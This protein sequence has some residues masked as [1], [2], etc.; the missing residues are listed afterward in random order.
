MKELIKAIRSAANMNQEQFAS[1]LG[2]TPLSI[3]RWE[4]GK[5]LPNRMA[6]TQLYNFCKERELD[7]VEIIVN[8][9]EY[10]D[11]N[12]KLVLYH[13]SKKGIDGDIAPISR[14]E[15]DFGKGFY[16]GTT[17]LQPL[18]LVCNEDKPKF[19][20]VEL[21]TTDLKVLTVDIG[22]D[23]AMLIAYYR[24]EM[25]SAKGT[26][27][28]EK[29]AHMADGYDLI[30]GYIA[31]DRMYT[32]L[33]RFFNRTLTDVALINCL[34]ALDLGKQYVAVSE[35]AC[36][37]IKVLKEYPLSQLELA[38][39]KDMSAERR[40]EGIALAEEI[41]VKYRREGKFFDEIL[42]GE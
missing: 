19:Y 31:N 9:K 8:A 23:W 30:I 4:N 37:Q 11:E 15:C 28:Y 40:K 1:A 24:K 18:T 2:T 17:T 20:A 16:M 35:K 6:Q 36:K 22:M 12:N 34:S 3:N 32:E 39:L 14:G 26:P 33:S 5:T 13:G 27:V 41:E 7:V 42:K 38:L 10:T 21:D 29:Y 25:E